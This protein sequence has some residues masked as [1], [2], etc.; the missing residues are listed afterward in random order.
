LGDQVIADGG[1]TL[2]AFRVMRTHVVQLAITM[3]NKGSGRHLFSL[4]KTALQTARDD[5]SLSTHSAR[6]FKH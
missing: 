5:L 4:F 2:W 6:R 3:R 1:Q